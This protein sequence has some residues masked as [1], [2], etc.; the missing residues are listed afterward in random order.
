MLAEPVRSTR[1][2]GGSGAIA[3]YNRTRPVERIVSVTVLA[4][5]VI[6][7]A[8]SFDTSW[9][10][11]S[12]DAS[13]SDAS[14][15]D[16]SSCEECGADA[17]CD[18]DGA[19]IPKGDVGAACSNPIQCKS[20]ICPEG[21][22]TCCEAGCSGPCE[23]CTQDGTCTLADENTMCASASCEA[24]QAQG[25]GMCDGSGE[26]KASVATSCAPY[27]CDSDGVACL[28]SCSAGGDASCIASHYCNGA[29][30]TPKKP[31]GDPC[32]G[33]GECMLGR[34]V[35]N[36]CCDSPCQ[37]ACESCLGTLTG[38]FDNGQCRP[39]TEWTDPDPNCQPGF[40]CDGNRACVPRLSSRGLVVRYFL[41]EASAGVPVVGSLVLDSAAAPLHLPVVDNDGL[42]YT[43]IGGRGLRW[44]ND[45]EDGRAQIDID[46]TKLHSA[47][48]QSRTAT[49]EV[50][51][52]I[53]D[54]GSSSSSRIVF[55]GQGS[56]IG[57]RLG[58]ATNNLLV[59]GLRFNGVTHGT[60]VVDL[61]G[62]GRSVVQVVV[63]TRLPDGQAFN[64]LRLYVNGEKISN[65]GTVP[66][67]NA[68]LDLG[69]GSRFVIGNRDDGDR[70]PEG[71]I[72]YVAM[73]S[74]AL[75]L[76]E[77]LQNQAGLSVDD[78]GP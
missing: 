54:V 14:S 78:D 16:A 18:G 21:T 60:W 55:L 46:G 10:G 47:L 74:E 24:G 41:D 65:L 9:N 28:N 15:I 58:L 5:A 29:V 50:V 57:R 23:A 34:C 32:T 64:R 69:S 17:Y 68:Q 56:G 1:V 31:N 36:V 6:G 3:T 25:P 8:C 38:D 13:V 59:L 19:C 70:S 43:G 77:I 51:M 45:G 7:G 63:D 62:Q 2:S 67:Q 48:H 72:Q 76:F 75:T 11:S 27:V 73:Y 61:L 71:A 33:N 37:G 20:G 42:A 40:V 26:C 39:I 44:D 4:L 53:D 12:R 49:I 30:C 66:A 35:E 22:R 52:D